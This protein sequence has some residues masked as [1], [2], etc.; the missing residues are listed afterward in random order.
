MA[1]CTGCDEGTVSSSRYMSSFAPSQPASSAGVPT[2]ALWS[3]PSSHQLGTGGANTVE[4]AFKPSSTSRSTPSPSCSRQAG[5][6]RKPP[7]LVPPPLPP[8]SSPS[9]SPPH[10]SRNRIQLRQGCSCAAIRRPWPSND[11][12]STF[13]PSAFLYGPV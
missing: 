6:H 12:A 1:R 10:F 4:L 5:G 8:S 2:A 11:S 13:L 9:S 7:L 3:L